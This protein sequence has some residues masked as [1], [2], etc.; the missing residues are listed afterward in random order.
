MKLLKKINNVENLFLYLFSICISLVKCLFKSFADHSVLSSLY[1]LDTRF[2]WDLCSVFFFFP[3]FGLSFHSHNSFFHRTSIFIL[4]ESL[5]T[6]FF[7]G[8]CFLCLRNHF[9][10]NGWKIFF[11]CSLMQ[12]FQNS[13]GYSRSLTFPFIKI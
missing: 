7:N 2:L 1:I 10:T 13:F 6:F 4:M 11:L 5:A 12:G 3:F 8:S 9:L